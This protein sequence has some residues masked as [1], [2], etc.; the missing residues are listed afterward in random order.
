MRY[1]KNPYSRKIS[2]RIC[3][4][5]V[6]GFTFFLVHV[7]QAQITT[8][9]TPTPGTFEQGNLGTLVDVP[10][11]EGANLVHDIT[12]GTRPGG[13]PTLHHSFDQLDVGENNVANF[14][15]ETSLPTENIL[16]RVTGGDSSNLFGTIQT[17]RFSGA[18]LFLLN[19]AGVVFG[20][21]ASLN[22]EGAFYSSTADLILLGQDGFFYANLDGETSVLTMGSPEAFGFLGENPSALAAGS[23]AGILVEG[24]EV[25]NGDSVGLV[26]RD[27]IAAG[28]T[29]EGVA[30]NGGILQNSG[31]SVKIASVGGPQLPNVQRVS[32]DIDTL[33]AQAFNS[34]SEAVLDPI[35]LG[36]ILLS[37]GA[38]IDTSGEGGGTVVVRGGVLMVE[39]SQISANTTGSTS[40]PLG[41]EAGVGIDIQVSH[42][43]L[44][45]SA[46]IFEANVLD[47][48]RGGGSLTLKAGERIEIRNGS[49]VQTQALAGS[50]NSGDIM[51]K[52]D[53]VLIS[54]FSGIE[55]SASPF[56]TGNTGNIFVEANGLQLEKISAIATPTFGPGQSGN[57]QVSVEGGEVVVSN[58]FIS[59]NAFSDGTAGNIQLTANNLQLSNFSKI[60]STS[61]LGTP[62]SVN[63]LL[64]GNLNV[65]ERASV[66]A[67]S[68]IAPGGEL[69]ITARDIFITGI[70]DSTDPRGTDFTGLTTF[71]MAGQGGDININADNLHV[72]DKGLVSSATRGPGNAGNVDINLTGNLSVS[73]QGGIIT[74]TRDVG[75]GGTINVGAEQ[76]SLTQN[77]FITA[78]ST[79]TGN[80]AGNAGNIQLTAV[81]TILV[82][83]STVTTQ[84]TQASG[85]NIN[86]QAEELIRLKDSTI[87]SSVEG[88]ATT[89]GGNVSLDP[90]FIIL[91]NSQILAKAVE[92]RGGNI[93]LV[94]TN[95]VL[96][97]PLSVLDAS[98]DLG[99]SGSVDIQAPIQNLSGTIAPLPEETT[100]VTGLYGARCA[101]GQGGNFSTFV[102][103][104]VDSFSPTPGRF[105]ASPL[106][107]PAADQANTVATSVGP[108]SPVMLTT[109][110]APLVL[111]YAGQ[112]QIACP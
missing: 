104:K 95:A 19:P 75:D 33:D 103:S 3:V 13:G 51:V 37:Q 74:D 111:G 29:V 20:P 42:D 86:L 53:T 43:L 89:V 112:P 57:I 34:Q 83:G 52:G 105:L 2:L 82:D 80:E 85:G 88:S 81:D 66:G 91:E 87:S 102:D 76:I 40:G 77:G 110:I 101:A 14:L 84:A 64:K 78:E 70:S 106:L 8:N 107:S 99:V 109:S 69:N 7:A 79:S 30:I 67:S 61:D 68:A 35:Q 38:K 5:V 54:Q 56:T 73:N 55:S 100:P 49:F 44:L 72:A 25:L 32:V 31:G 48:S 11:V 65:Q 23:A 62:G 26:G 46:S 47:S 97:D 39:G 17:T 15:N 90:E 63:L 41:S 45:D 21:N 9:I 10:R 50:G 27:A 93:S 1:R 36:G 60:Q 24:L 92:G 71:T 4:E 16:S 22:V 94:A 59:A 18:N 108:Q 6:T 58:G 12:G 96:V 28:T 98:S